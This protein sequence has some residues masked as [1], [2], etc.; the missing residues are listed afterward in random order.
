M[1]HV[2]PTKSRPSVHSAISEMVETVVME[3]KTVVLMGDLNCNLTPINRLGELLKQAMDDLYLT[4][5]IN[6]PT[7]IS[8][9]SSTLIDVIFTSSP[10]HFESSGTL[11]F[12]GSDHLMVYGELTLRVFNSPH[13]VTLR[14]FGHCV[15]D[16]LLSDLRES[17]WSVMGMYNDIDDKWGYWKS[18]YLK[19]VNKHAP[20]LTFRKKRDP[21]PW[22]TS[23]ILQLLHN[24]NYFKKKFKQTKDQGDWEM[25]KHLR[26]QVTKL[27]ILKRFV[28][29][30]GITLGEHGTS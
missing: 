11:L 27:S 6:K 21:H 1:Q 10:G 23:E 17:H 26:H 8:Q 5:I 22:V 4:Q 29:T 28:T 18:L 15:E 25:Y 16:D 9:F 3:N 12:T 2:S 7:R 30:L 14:S 20:V 19:I 13:L 24:R